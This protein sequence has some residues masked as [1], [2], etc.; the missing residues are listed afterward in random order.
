MKIERQFGEATLTIEA[1][2]MARQASGAVTV[3]CGDTLVLVTAVATEQQRTGIDFVPLTVDYQERFY[4]VGRIPGNFFRREVGRPSEK[5]TLTSRF[6]DRPC[7]P[8]FPK[9]WNYE[10]QVIATALSVDENYDPDILAMIGASAAL[11]ISDIPFA[12]PIA[13]T[14]V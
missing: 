14:K 13:G 12:G 4:A 6:I 8:L 1:G 7:R 2:H 9:T 10:T 11:Q 3:R 5:E